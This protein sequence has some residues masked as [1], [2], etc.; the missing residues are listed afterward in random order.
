MV[1]FFN[2][3][4]HTVLVQSNYHCI[5]LHAFLDFDHIRPAPDPMSLSFPTPTG[6]LPLP[7]QYFLFHWSVLIWEEMWHLSIWILLTLLNMVYSPDHIRAN[8]L[9]L[10][11]WPNNTP[12]CTDTDLLHWPLLWWTPGLTA[13]AGYRGS[14]EVGACW[15]GVL[16]YILVLSLTDFWCISGIPMNPY[17]RVPLRGSYVL[18]CILPLKLK[19]EIYL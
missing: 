5:F 4:W 8:V 12:V 18:C 11:F 1:A 10:F 19:K 9:I 16:R 6:L 2:F 14:M 3:Y 13:R 7:P 17:S 15:P